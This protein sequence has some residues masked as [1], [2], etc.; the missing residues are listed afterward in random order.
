METENDFEW[1]IIAAIALAFVLGLA[2]GH[3]QEWHWQQHEINA[4]KKQIERQKCSDINP[5]K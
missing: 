5:F 4:L 1:G 3:I 2:I